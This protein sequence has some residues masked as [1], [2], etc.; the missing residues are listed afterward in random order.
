MTGGPHIDAMCGPS[1]GVV[2]SRL[3]PC[4]GSSAYQKADVRAVVE[5]FAVGGDRDGHAGGHLEF[6]EL[7][8]WPRRLMVPK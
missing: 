6:V 8:A 4:Q 5:A 7:D 2:V 3:I 1:V